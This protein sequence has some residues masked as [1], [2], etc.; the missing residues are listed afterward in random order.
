[1]HSTRTTY[2]LLTVIWCVLLAKFRERRW[3]KRFM[4]LP[5]P[6]A[7]KSTTPGMALLARIPLS[8]YVSSLDILWWSRV[9]H[10][11][12]FDCSYPKSYKLTH[13][14][15]SYSLILY[16]IRAPKF[17]PNNVLSS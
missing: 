14:V 16:D 9:T 11:E 1:M 12:H 5:D 3:N 10:S 15:S 4:V 8:V 17:L 13:E 2:C 7:T 6:R